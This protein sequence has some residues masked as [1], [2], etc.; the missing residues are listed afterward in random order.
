MAGGAKDSEGQYWTW[1]GHV[2]I[3]AHN[4]AHHYWDGARWQ[5]REQAGFWQQPAWDGSDTTRLVLWAG[6]APVALVG[7]AALAIRSLPLSRGGVLAVALSLYALWVIVGGA[8]VRYEGRFREQLVITAGTVSVLFVVGVVWSASA[9]DT[10]K[11]QALGLVMTLGFLL[12]VYPTALFLLA[13]RALR[14]RID[15]RRARPDAG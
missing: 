6:A 5:V 8:T 3:P 12:L 11:N 7:V 4:D 9:V 1:N 2:W 13:G 15:T 10:E 14:T